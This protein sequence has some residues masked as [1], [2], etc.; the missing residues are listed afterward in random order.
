VI[1]SACWVSEINLAAAG[2]GRLLPL[3]ITNEVL[4]VHFF[5]CSGTMS[6]NMTP[7]ALAAHNHTADNLV[8]SWSEHAEKTFWSGH[9]W[10]L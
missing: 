5:I 10:G 7:K 6:P 8:T 3:Y 4:A 1:A 2:Y 9:R